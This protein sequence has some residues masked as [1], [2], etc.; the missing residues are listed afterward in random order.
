MRNKSLKDYLLLALWLSLSGLATSLVAAPE[1]TVPAGIVMKTPDTFIVNDREYTSSD[2]IKGLKKNKIPT[3]SPLIVEVPADTS[4][5]V[6]K[7]LTQRLATAGYKPFFK[8]PRHADAAVKDP[9][10]PLTP[11]VTPPPPK[12]QR[13][14][15]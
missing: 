1:V 8:Y 14:R 12:K 6:I 4:M 5:T 15:K 7:D 3:A 2:L 11:P 9:N 13:S 10:A